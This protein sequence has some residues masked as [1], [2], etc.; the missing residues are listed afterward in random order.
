MKMVLPHSGYGLGNDLIPWAKGF[1]LAKELDAVLLHPAWGNNP[2]KYYKYFNT[3]KYDHLF[4]R[5]LCRI[6]PVYNFSEEDYREIGVNGFFESAKIFAEKSGIKNKKH[7]IL[8]LTGPWGAFSGL[9]TARQFVLSCLHNT[10]YTQNNLYNLYKQINRDQLTVGVHV[11]RGDFYE[12]GDCEYAGKGQTSIKINWYVQL[13]DK[14]EQ[15][16]GKRKVQFILCSD[17]NEQELDLLTARENVIFASGLENS[18]IS[19]MLILQQSDLLICSISSYSMWAAFL[20]DAPYIWYR[21]NLIEESEGIVNRF[22]RSLGIQSNTENG[23]GRAFALSDDD[24]LPE[25]LIQ[26]LITKLQTKN[27]RFDLVRAGVLNKSFDS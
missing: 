22:I 26:Q 15:Q 18:D 7:Y 17:G 4:Y 12:P 13:L 25:Q 3:S 11:R 19:D 9:E 14:I 23:I 24:D 10:S 6:I 1:I 5:V 20:G 2:R 8:K 27:T 21:P 16:I